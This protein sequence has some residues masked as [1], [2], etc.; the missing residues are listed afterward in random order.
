MFLSFPPSN[1]VFKSAWAHVVCPLV[2]IVSH[3]SAEHE[4]VFYMHQ[5]LFKNLSKD[6]DWRHVRLPVARD[7]RTCDPQMWKYPIMS[8]G[9]WKLLNWVVTTT[10]FLSPT[11]FRISGHSMHVRE[12][13]ISAGEEHVWYYRGCLLNSRCNIRFLSFFLFSFMSSKLQKK[14]VTFYKQRE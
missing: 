14:P 2:S 6:E 7:L 1:A 4:N 3:C 11:R 12:S 8:L 10:N 5:I 9:W 13:I